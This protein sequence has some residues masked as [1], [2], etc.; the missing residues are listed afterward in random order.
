MGR[1]IFVSYKYADYDVYNIT[2]SYSNTVR[3]YV[4]KIEELIGE[5]DHIYKAESDGEDLSHLSEEQIWTKLKNRIYDSTLTIILISKNM[6]E[7]FKD[8]KN[9]WIPREVSYSLKAVSRSNKNGDQIT[10]NENA[11]LAV[12]IPDS[13]NSYSYYIDIRNCCSEGCRLYSNNNIF[14]ILSENMFNIKTP[15]KKDCTDGKTIYYGDSSYMSVV[16]WSDFIDDMDNYIN[17]AYEI[18]GNIDQ[19][20]ICKEIK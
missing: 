13:L 14:Q 5:T 8:E 10:S 15:N 7:A 18:Q 17:K 1:K 12:V 4:N 16:K 9:Q 20:D 19:Y 11:L 3:D 2:G 6:K